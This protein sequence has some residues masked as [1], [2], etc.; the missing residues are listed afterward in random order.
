M[1]RCEEKTCE[2]SC[3]TSTPATAVLSTG[4]PP[5]SNESGYLGEPLWRRSLA[6]FSRNGTLQFT[7]ILRPDKFIPARLRMAYL[8]HQVLLDQSICLQSEI[9][10]AGRRAQASQT[11]NIH[12]NAEDFSTSLSSV[13]RDDQRSAAMLLGMHPLLPRI[14]GMNVRQGRALPERYRRGRG[15]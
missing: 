12:S 5:Q 8:Q 4:T 7:A 6:R 9:D 2:A 3:S 15:Q 13:K 1:H 11:R 14:V 10:A